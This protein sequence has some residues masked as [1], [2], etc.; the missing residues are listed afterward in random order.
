MFDNKWK[1]GN[2]ELELSQLPGNLFNTPLIKPIQL[3]KKGSSDTEIMLLHTLEKKDAKKFI[4]K[5]ISI[6]VKSG[7]IYTSYG[8]VCFI[9]FSIPD[10]DTDNVYTYEN[11][12]NPKKN[13]ELSV[14]KRLADQKYWHL[15]VADKEKNVVTFF[16]FSNENSLKESLDQIENA[17]KDLEV[18]D[19]KAAKKEYENK[20][21]VEQLLGF[22]NFIA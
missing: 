11:T 13:D 3:F 21:T 5:D 9:L 7:V 10:P 1:D 2:V 4:D 16:E 6:D 20:Y 22:S 12:I 18:T 15:I 19:F 14:Y 17:C 8:P